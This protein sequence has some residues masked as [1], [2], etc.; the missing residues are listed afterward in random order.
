MTV[1]FETP[2]I[3]TERLTLRGPRFEDFEPWFSFI[4]SD[5]A[6]M[7]G[8]PLSDRRLAWNAFSQMAAQWILRG[9]GTFIVTLKGSENAV[10]AV[11]PYYP[12]NWPEKELGWTCWDPELEGT[13]LMFEAASAARDFAFDKL[14]WE[15]AVSYIDHGNDRSVALAERL[16]AVLDPDAKQTKPDDPCFVYRHPK[17]RGAT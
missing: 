17:Q 10:A 8:G 16:G 5:R 15:T 6:S 3:H 1:T 9:F 7:A 12:I 2:T 14:G 11:G 4:S 13:G